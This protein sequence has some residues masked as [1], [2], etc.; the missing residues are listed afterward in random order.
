[1]PVSDEFEFIKIIQ[2]TKLMQASLLVG[3]GDDA[4]LYESVPAMDQIV[5]LDTMQEG[6]HFLR[7]TMAPY[8]IG[9]KGLASNISD[10]A[11]MGG[12]PLFYLVSISIPEHWDE[13]ELKEIYR[14]MAELAM[15][16]N[17]DL[18]GG[19]T[20][21]S[22][23]DLTLSI[24]VIGMVEKGK[25]LLRSNAR[26]GDI[27]FVS[28]CPGESA[29]GLFLLQAGQ[30]AAY[31][32][33]EQYLVKRHQRPEPRVELG[34]KLVTLERVALNDISDGLASELN[35]IA[36]ASNV[37]IVINRAN[38]PKSE[39]LAIFD[40]QQQ[41]QWMMVGGEDY[42]LVGTMPVTDW[43]RLDEDTLHK[44]RLTRIGFVKEG[45]PSVYIEDKD[46]L[47]LLK[48]KGF[49]HFGTGDAK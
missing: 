18:I 22:K 25:R 43:E 12:V 34:R 45:A 7:D 46:G 48:K 42:E 29:A 21:A 27:V 16:Y 19:D 2:P 3:I 4:A 24:T 41:L 8:D 47:V 20:V 39:Y 28:G 33:Y 49:N 14:G 44:Y 26:P 6:V 35:E 1:M 38:L 5:C 10:I 17:M 15:L 40:E 30:V 13:E 31:N 32:E 23:H 9:Y 11:A 36:E 37:Q